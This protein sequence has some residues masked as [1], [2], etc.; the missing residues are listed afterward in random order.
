MGTTYILW[1]GALAP[2]A[3]AGTSRAGGG[4]RR[5]DDAANAKRPRAIPNP[6]IS[7]RNSSVARGIGIAGASVFT[8]VRVNGVDLVAVPFE[9]VM[10]SG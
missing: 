3:I 1:A 10:M 4:L 2:T 8:M 7:R 9:P 6:A 5:R